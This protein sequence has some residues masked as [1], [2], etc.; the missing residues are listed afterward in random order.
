MVCLNI[1]DV[2]PEKK[3]HAMNCTL[4]ISTFKHNP[5]QLANK[6]HEWNEQ[7]FNKLNFIKY[8]C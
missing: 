6:G 7:Y 2:V 3:T 8:R 5:K 1:Y 4:S